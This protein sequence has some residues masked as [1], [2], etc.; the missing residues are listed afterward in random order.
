[1]LN[2]H[3][4]FYHSTESDAFHGVILPTDA[5]EAH[6]TQAKN[7]IRDHL[8]EAIERASIVAL[9]QPK[10]VTPRFRTQGSWSYSLCNQPAH[11]PPQEMDW[12]LGVYLPVSVWEESQPRFAAQAYYK[13]LEDSLR[14]LCARERWTMTPKETCIRVHIGRAAHIDVPPYAAP[15]KQ[16]AAIQERVLAKALALKESTAVNDA[17]AFGEMPG[18][19][20]DTLTDIVLAT[21]SGKWEKSDPAVVSDWFRDRVAEFGDQFRRICRYLK[22]WRDFQ[23]TEGGP[24]SV[25]LMVC[26]AQSFKKMPGRDDAALL[27]V[28][29]ELGDRLAGE[30]RE[31]LI[32]P[33]DDFNKKLSPDE[34]ADAAAKARAF[35]GALKS[36]VEAAS[37][38][39]AGVLARLK[40][41][42]GS[43]FPTNPAWVSDS[44]PQD[45]VRVAPVIAVP[46]PEVRRTNSG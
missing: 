3:R 11:V 30:V 2:L 22:A 20:W 44:T 5:Q 12:D 6:L 21:R 31:E 4:L 26:A 45:I 40:T 41:E 7:K 33:D 8:R 39:K 46:Q 10:K 38:Q 13:L 42:F 28:A 19:E 35:Y 14:S 15:D 23:W 29:R 17:I 1:M 24:S 37:Y 9:G 36:A 25:C 16:F 34:R 27:E 18:E 32:N 43:R